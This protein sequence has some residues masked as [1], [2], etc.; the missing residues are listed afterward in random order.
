MKAGIFIDDYKLP[1][2]KR[3]LDEA[4]YNYEVGK[5]LADDM[6]MITV[7]TNDAAALGEVVK[8]ANFEAS[9]PST[10]ETIH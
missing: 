3:Y 1:V 7:E 5:G 4:K 10:S 8:A 6:L 2:F 9:I